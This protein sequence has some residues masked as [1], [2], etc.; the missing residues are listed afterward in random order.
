MSLAIEN[1]VLSTFI[2]GTA[3]LGMY[4]NEELF[5]L[6]P[7][8]FTGKF[9]RRLAEIANESI[10]N[11]APLSEIYFDIDEKVADLNSN[12]QDA[13]LNILATNPLP[14]EDAKYYHKK[15]TEQL[16]RRRIAHELAR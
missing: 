1:A 6:N 12:N 7:D 8:V 14:V 13:W 5:L 16:I 2:T 11:G 10:T 3:V 4:S 9:R 15:L